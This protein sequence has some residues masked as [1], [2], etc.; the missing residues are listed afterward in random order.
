VR[1]LE[2]CQA[3]LKKTEAKLVL[4][5]QCPDC[6]ETGSHHPGCSHYDEC[7]DLE[8]ENASLTAALWEII[9]EMRMIDQEDLGVRGIL[10][11]H[12]IPIPE[13]KDVW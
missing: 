9:D 10:E 12:N 11:K 2:A 13:G 4:S 8:K 1:Q 6:G 5:N 7:I 3:A